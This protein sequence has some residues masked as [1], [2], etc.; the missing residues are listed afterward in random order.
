MKLQKIFEENNRDY[1]IY[2]ETAFIHEGCKEYL[3]E[4]IDKSVKSG[5][6]GI[7]FQ[8]I[9]DKTGTYT[10]GSNL[11]KEIDRWMF[12]EKEWVEIISYAKNQNLETIVLPID[13]KTMDI[14]SKN[15]K[16][17]DA[18]EIHATCINDYFMLRGI[19]N[20]KNK[21]VLLGIC[22]KLSDN[23]AICT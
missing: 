23:I 1:Y 22:G 8:V 18:I 17:I 7:K 21:P 4:L 20:I 14:I 12:S 6:D 9:L 19:S 15:K 11:F 3:L 13:L 2:A 16:I 10:K 5:C